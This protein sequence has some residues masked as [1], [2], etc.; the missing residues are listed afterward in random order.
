MTKTGYITVTDLSDYA[1]LPH[2]VIRKDIKAG[3]LP[4]ERYGNNVYIHPEDARDYVYY[5]CGRLNKLKNI[6][7]IKAL[8]L[9]K[10]GV[11]FGRIA[12]NND[13]E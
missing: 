3:I 4:I 5:T 8:S 10:L 13:G 6:K 7:N 1:L 2:G 12:I 11:H 9:I